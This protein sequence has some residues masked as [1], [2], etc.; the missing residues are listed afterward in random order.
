[1]IC[2]PTDVQNVYILNTATQQEIVRSYKQIRLC[3]Y[4]NQVSIPYTP[5]SVIRLYIQN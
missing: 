4:P 2:Q 1:M 5:N 3:K